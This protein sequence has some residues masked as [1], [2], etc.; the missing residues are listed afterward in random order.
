MITLTVNIFHNSPDPPKN[1]VKVQMEKIVALMEISEN[2]QQHMVNN[3]SNNILSDFG[4]WTDRDGNQIKY[5]DGN[6]PIG[7]E[8]CKCSLDGTGCTLNN[9]G[10]EVCRR[11]L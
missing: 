9:L 3:C 7:T 5:W 1:S 8:G 10:Q 2:C 11:F 4:W 6:H